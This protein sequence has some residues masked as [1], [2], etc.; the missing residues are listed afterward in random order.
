MPSVAYAT[1]F[2]FDQ[3]LGRRRR[4]RRID[5]VT[6]TVAQRHTPL[7]GTHIMSDQAQQ[8]MALGA[9]PTQE[10]ESPG[11]HSPAAATDEHHHNASKQSNHSASWWWPWQTKNSIVVV[12]GASGAQG[13]EVA[14]ALLHD[15]ETTFTVGRIVVVGCPTC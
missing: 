5:S 15:S 11:S 6:A 14:K 8:E 12:T 2:T 3:R 13:Y 7:E 9:T 1:A 10:A 4:R